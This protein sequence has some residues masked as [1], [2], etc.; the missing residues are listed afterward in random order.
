[1]DGIEPYWLWFAAGLLLAGLEMVVPGV[2]LIRLAMAALA[3]G[4][5]F[6]S[7]AKLAAASFDREIAATHKIGCRP[8]RIARTRL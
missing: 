2:H 4:G 3:T 7:A 8:R 5:E 1:M 6:F